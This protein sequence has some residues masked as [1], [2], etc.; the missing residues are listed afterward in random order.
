[1]SDTIYVYLVD[2]GTDVWRPVLAEHIRD[3]MY[4]ITSAPP[5]DTETWEFVTGETVRCRAKNFAGGEHKM[6]VYERVT[7]IVG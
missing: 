6:V 2:E 5:D 4:R 7:S 3:D 1:M